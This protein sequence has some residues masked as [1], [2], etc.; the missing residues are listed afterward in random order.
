[1]GEQFV[2]FVRPIGGEPL[3]GVA[4]GPMQFAPAAFQ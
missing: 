2:L 1:M 4:G 3:D